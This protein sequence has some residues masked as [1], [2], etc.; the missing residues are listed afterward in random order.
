MNNLKILKFTS[1]T[2]EFIDSIVELDRQIFNSPFSKEV[3][4]NEVDGRKD[5]LGLIAIDEDVPCGFIVGFQHS[6]KIFYNWI[7]GVHPDFRR[8]G[9]ARFLMTEQDRILKTLEYK[10]IR[11]H[12]KNEYRDML[13]LSIKSGFDVIGTQK[14]T[15]ETEHSII[16]E[17]EL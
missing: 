5:L 4:L 6:P 3:I 2:D 15:G 14:K 13:I 16:L 7:V 11:T 17:K 10:Y 9:V 8:R 12:T 1:I